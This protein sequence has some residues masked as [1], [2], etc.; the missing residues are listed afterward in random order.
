M[1]N[2]LDSNKYEMEFSQAPESQHMSSTFGIND[3]VI[4]SG[5]SPLQ[6]NPILEANNID[7]ILEWPTFAGLNSIRRGFEV[8]ILAEVVYDHSHNLNTTH[9]WVHGDI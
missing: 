1:V 6:R 5:H 7:V 4:D 3:L 9:A 2:L 8:R